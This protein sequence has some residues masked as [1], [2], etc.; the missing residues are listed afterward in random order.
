MSQKRLANLQFLG[1]IPYFLG[2][3]TYFL[4]NIRNI[5]VSVAFSYE[6]WLFW[7]QTKRVQG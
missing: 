5:V 3:I 4:G 2:N 7:G 6:V 1:N